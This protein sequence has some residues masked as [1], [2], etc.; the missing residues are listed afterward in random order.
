[1]SGQMQQSRMKYQG[2]GPGGAYSGDPGFFSFVGGLAKKAVGVGLGAVPVVGSSLQSGWRG[3]TGGP[4]QPGPVSSVPFR[5]QTPNQKA[6][7]LG[8]SGG[9]LSRFLGLSSDE[10]GT[11]DPGGPQTPGTGLVNR[12]QQIIPGGATGM[13]AAGRPAGYHAN[14]SSYWLNDGTHVPAGTRWVKNRRR[15]PLNPRALSKAMGR[16]TSFKGAATA[17]SRITIRKKKGCR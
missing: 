6:S 3:L 9:G 4:G 7:V 1:M 17:A 13:V 8:L 11:Y 16:V 5:L 10:Q 12:I 2:G 14:K 15:N